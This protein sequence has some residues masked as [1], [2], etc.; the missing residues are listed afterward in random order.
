MKTIITPPDILISANNSMFL[1]EPT[2]EMSTWFN[3]SIENLPDEIYTYIYPRC[4]YDIKW[5]LTIAKMSTLVVIDVDSVSPSLL[6][7]TSFIISLPQT[8]YYS[9]NVDWLMISPRRITDYKNIK[10]QEI[11]ER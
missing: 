5:L 3:N 11:Y 1:I 9:K 8:K 6:P 7:W 10:L 2:A 4:H